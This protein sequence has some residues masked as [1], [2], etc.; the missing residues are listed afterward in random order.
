[1]TH[2]AKYCDREPELYPPRLKTPSS[3]LVASCDGGSEVGC[4]EGQSSEASEH[5]AKLVA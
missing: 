3:R 1:M 4:F 5:Q 2:Q